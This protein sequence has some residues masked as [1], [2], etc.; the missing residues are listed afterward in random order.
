MFYD[1]LKKTDCQVWLV[2]TGYFFIKFRWVNGKYGIGT[3]IAFEDSLNII[4][5]IMDG[6]LEKA[7]TYRFSHFN[8]EVPEKCNGID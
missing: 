8:F 5:Q 3:R 1:K 2:N 7:P 4:S 6:S